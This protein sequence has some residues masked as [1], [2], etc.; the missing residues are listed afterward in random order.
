MFRGRV[1]G[2]TREA[3]DAGARGGVHDRAAALLEH[4]RD[5]VLHAQE[6]AA[7]VDADDPV[8]LLLGEIG[9]SR[10][11]LFDAGVV[12]GEV[13]APECLDRLVESSPHVVGPRH[14]APDGE[15]APAEF[16][17]HAGCFLIP[18]FGN[19]THHHARAL[20]GKRQR[21]RTADAG[22]RAGEERRLP[23]EC[24]VLIRRSHSLLPLALLFYGRRSVL[25]ARRSSM[26]R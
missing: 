21:R 26:T 22:R 15:R 8:P 24:S 11:R 10:D 20:A 1:R 2:L 4:Q 14:V 9:R 25:I 17:D 18:P 13:E 12:E 23:R 19:I 5:F 6:H 16:F 7:E 3:F